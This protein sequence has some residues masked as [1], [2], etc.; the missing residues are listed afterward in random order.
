MSNKFLLLFLVFLVTLNGVHALEDG[1]SIPLVA[2]RSTDGGDEGVLLGAKVIVTNGT[3]HVFVDTNPYTQVDLQGSARLA[4]MVASDVL[5][6][7]Q[8]SY[9]FYYIID[10]SSP[11]IGGPSAGGALTVATIAAINK[12]TLKPGVV[13]TGMI[14]PD[15]SIGPVG[16]IPYKLEAAAASNATLFLIPQGQSTVTIKKTVTTSKGALI[17]PEEKEETVDVVELGKKL[18][19]TVKEVNTIQDAVLAFTDRELTKPLYKG[20][21]LTPDYLSLLEPLA[22]NLKNESRGMYEN[23]VSSVPK[24]QFV[25]QAKDIL[26]RADKMYDDKKYYAATSSYFNA[27][28]NLRVAQWSDGYSKAGDKEQYLTELVN[29]VEKQIQSSESDLSNFTLYGISDVEAAGAAESRIT[30]ARAKLDE[31]KKLKDVDAKIFSLA[32]ANERARTAQWWLT[33]A[34]PE[35]KI[36]PG[37]VLKDRAGWYLSQAQSINTYMQTLIAESGI[38][39]EITNAAGEDIVHAQKEMERGYYAGA[40]FDSLQATIKASTTI[41]LL[42]NADADKKIE[43]SMEAAK[44]AINEARLAGIEPTLAVSAYEYAETI[45]NT[46][47]KIS[48]YSYAKMIAKTSVVLNSRAVSSDKKPV[49]PTITP[50][51]PEPAIP[52]PT[53]TAKTQKTKI[54]IPAFEAIAAI[55]AVLIVRRLNKR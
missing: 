3:G 36:V 28:I 6:I 43:Q 38:H 53:A 45:P 25:E 31:A 7:D 32:F 18:N 14:N 46:Y 23:T 29:K 9:D 44:V 49:K 4:A 17:I 51:I 34:T 22:S 37:S 5:G 39:P 2:D 27:M 24:S 40:I 26:T 20:A 8:K 11:I 48:Q 12:W 42:G 19:V 54:E 47:D 35:D 50:Y 52:T 13:M 15:E 41:G 16:G 1:V 10:I 55:A 21:I 30:T 33:L